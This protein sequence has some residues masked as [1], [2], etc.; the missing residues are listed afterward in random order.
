MDKERIF[1]SMAA[2][3]A[4]FEALMQEGQLTGWIDEDNPNR[5]EGHTDWV[6]Y[7]PSHQRACWLSNGDSVWFN[8]SSLDEAVTLAFCGL[9]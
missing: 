9:E 4:D 1:S 7:L 6:A 3:Q 2:N 8:A 5:T